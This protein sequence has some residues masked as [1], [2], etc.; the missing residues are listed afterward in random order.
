MSTEAVNGLGHG[1]GDSGD[2]VKE[3]DPMND[4]SVKKECLMTE[5]DQ[6]G[7]SN[8]C[9]CYVMDDQGQYEDPCYMPV[10]ACCLIPDKPSA[11]G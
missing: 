11:E 6:R 2:D 7:N 3:G 4:K 8:L 10:D 1:S 9:C 5:K